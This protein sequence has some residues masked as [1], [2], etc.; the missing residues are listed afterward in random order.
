MPDRCP[1]RIPLRRLV[2]LNDGLLSPRS[3]TKL[4]RHIEDGCPA[5]RA[6]LS[7]LG[8]TLTAVAE[9][10]LP[11]PPS[12]LARSAGRLLAKHRR[13]AAVDRVRRAVCRLLFDEWV[14]PVPAL[15]SAPGRG[16]RMLFSV[17]QGEL[18][19]TFTSGAGRFA[20]DGEM[21]APVREVILLKDGRERERA[22]VDG[23][24]RFRFAGLPGGAF[25]LAG[26][27]EGEEFETPAIVV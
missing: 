1:D 3:A 18:F 15:R 4:S 23:E 19:L 12:T 16:R 26:T 13:R 8:R 7:E 27:V 5:C 25:T 24:G 21:L 20:I 2:D 9:G 10:P 22:A 14:E 11:P 6:R 17:G